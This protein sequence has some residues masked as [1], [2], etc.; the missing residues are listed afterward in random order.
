[1]PLSQEE[2]GRQFTPEEKEKQIEIL[3]K[4]REAKAEKSAA[5]AKAEEEEK[6]L[7]TAIIK[8]FE[9][10]PSHAPVEGG[11]PAINLIAV[12]KILGLVVNEIKKVKPEEKEEEEPKKKKEWVGGHTL[13]KEPTG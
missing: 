12:D 10:Y 1:M 4:A 7:R 13:D 3:R 9:E 2:K 6:A 8:I 11:E 5:K